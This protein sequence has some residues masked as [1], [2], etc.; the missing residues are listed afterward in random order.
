MGHTRGRCFHLGCLHARLYQVSG[1]SICQGRSSFYS[2]NFLDNLHESAFC[3]AFYA[4]VANLSSVKSHLLILFVRT[5]W[6]IILCSFAIASVGFSALRLG[7]NWSFAEVPLCV[8]K[9]VLLAPFAFQGSPR[10]SLYSSRPL[11]RKSLVTVQ[12]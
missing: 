3:L 6:T 12:G 5:W 10:V 9:F 2:F 4:C 11:L 7:A 8:K 1:R